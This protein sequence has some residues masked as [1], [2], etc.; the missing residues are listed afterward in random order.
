[1]AYQTVVAAFDTPEHA[2]AAVNAL[3]AGGFHSDD[4]SVFNKDRLPGNGGLKPKLNEPGLWRRLFGGDIHEHEAAVFGQTVAEGGTVISV[5]T[6]DSEV[7]HATGILDVHRPLD[8]HD[9]AITTGLAPAARVES[10]AREVAAA[11]LLEPQ[12]IA[13]SP[14]AAD[15]HGDMLR[16]AEEQLQ[17]GKEM[18]ETGRTRVRRFT[19]EREV[20]QDISLHDEHAE[21]LRRAVAEPA[22]YKDVD[23]ADSEIEVVETAEHALKNKTA[24]IVEEIALKK[25]G[26]D[27]VETITDRLR[28][29][30]AEVVRTDAQGRP[31]SESRPH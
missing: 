4:I 10:I 14:K 22:S 28:R 20:S 30:Q 18:M 11:P 21:V 7:A 23:W 19:T 5:R 26:T 16:L 17:V 24:R 2:Q 3:R 1:M 12:R 13:T 29:Q 8:V 15:V 27:H 9:R 6:L 31:I 25:V